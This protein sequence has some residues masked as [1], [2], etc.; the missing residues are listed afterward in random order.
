MLLVKEAGGMMS[1]F[2]GGND[3]LTS[4]N[5]VC[6]APKVFKPLLQVVGKHMG[7]I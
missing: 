1:D 4:G 6:A 2:R 5:I 3:M 7:A